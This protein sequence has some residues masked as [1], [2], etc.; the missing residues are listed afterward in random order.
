[1]SEKTPGEVFF[2]V[3]QRELSL[4]AG[5]V[6]CETWMEL[7]QCERDAIELAAKAVRNLPAPH[8]MIGG[9]EWRWCIDCGGDGC[10]RIESGSLYDGNAVLVD[11]KSCDGKG[12]I[13]A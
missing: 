1:M 7:E 11:C 5:F 2:D 4:H 8:G 9:R 12:R 3:V 6:P 10:D 13:P